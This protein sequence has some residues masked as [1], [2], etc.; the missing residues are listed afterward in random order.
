METIEAIKTRHSTR[1]FT[2]QPVPDEILTQ[3]VADAQLAPSWGNSQPWRVYIATGDS[4]ERIKTRFH[5]DAQNGLTE[6]ADLSKAH[7]GDFSSFA[8]QNMGHWVGTFRP[9]IESDSETYW[10]SRNHLYRATAI[11]YLVLDQNP[12][13]WSIYDLGA[14]SQNLMLSATAR[15]IQ[16]V[17]SY[18]LVK[19]PDVI[20]EELH[21][22]KDKVIAMGIALGYEKSDKNLNEYRSDRIPTEQILSITH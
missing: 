16:S 5:D 13:S 1:A 15:G 7:R 14:F 6:N 4:L 10:D 22:P 20:R 12:N 21:L 11:A 2:D 9:V 3:I 19:Y 8:S 17:P 18:E